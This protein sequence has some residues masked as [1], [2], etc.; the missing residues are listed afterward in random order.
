MNLDYHLPD[1][2]EEALSLLGQGDPLGGGTALTP[3]RADLQGVIDLR[4]LGLDRIELDERRLEIGATAT[5]QAL[6]EADP[7]AELAEACRR[8]AGWNLRNQATLAGA[9]VSADGRSPLAAVLLAMGAELRL[10]PGPETM[11]L[12]PFFSQRPIEQ[13]IVSIGMPR[14]ERL[15]YEQVARSPA[16]RPQV[17]VAAALAEGAVRVAL[18]G[19]GDRPLLV[20]AELAAE[21]GSAEAVAEAAAQAYAQAGDQWASAEYRS[22]A[23][24]ALARR[25]VGGLVGS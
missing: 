8:E 17:C 25:V 7:P 11:R 18:G 21:P 2:L 1:S 6:L 23:A 20:E 10:E 22:A 19:Y 13:L 16:D 12:D 5:L 4:R 9:L 14:P 24:Q 3:R 15:A